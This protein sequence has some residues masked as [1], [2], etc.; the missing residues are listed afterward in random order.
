[1]NVFS[2]VEFLIYI[3]QA[4]FIY[5]FKIENSSFALYSRHVWFSFGPQQTLNSFDR[6][7]SVLMT[8]CLSK[9]INPAVYLQDLK[10]I[11]QALFS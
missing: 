7:W 3:F 2:A 1:M 5:H 8:A 11:I 6:N 4:G 10:L 9:L